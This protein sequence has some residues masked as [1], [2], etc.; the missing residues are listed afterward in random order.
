MSSHNKEKEAAIERAREVLRKFPP[1]LSDKDYA[2]M[3]D[4][5]GCPKCGRMIYCGAN[6]LCKDTECGLKR[7]DKV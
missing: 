3:E 4:Y 5:A 6:R 7:N 1:F 2:M